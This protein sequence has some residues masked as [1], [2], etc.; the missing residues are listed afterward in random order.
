MHHLNKTLQLTTSRQLTLP[1]GAVVLRIVVTPPARTTAEPKRMPLNIGIALD[2]SG[3]MDGAKLSYAKAA[4]QRLV[5]RMTDVDSCALVTFENKSEIVFASMPMHAQNRSFATD[6][7]AKLAT[8][9][10]TALH[11]GWHDAVQAVKAAAE[12]QDALQRV[13]LLTDG[14]ANVGITDEHVLAQLAARAQSAGVATTTFG[15][16]DGYNEALLSAM[17]SAGEGNTYYIQEPAE[18][19]TFFEQELNQLFSTSM[20]DATLSVSYTSDLDVQVIGDRNHTRDERGLHFPMGS[21]VQDESRDVYLYL[22]ARGDTSRT[23]FHLMAELFGST[24]EGESVSS[25]ELLM[26]TVA[27]DTG[28]IDS[29]LEQ[30]AAGIDAAAAAAIALDQLS[31]VDRETALAVFAER[32][33]RFPILAGYPAYADAKRRLPR[34][35]D[36]AEMKRSRMEMNDRVNSSPSVLIKYLFMLKE[37]QNRGAPAEEIARMEE[38]IAEMRKRYGIE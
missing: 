34:V 23:V 8:R 9:G 19:D 13:F 18:I 11:A 14:Q 26:L 24:P 7:I 16:G 28:E 33:A 12:Q 5:S 38:R 3:S 36:F 1:N 22:A 15:L 30:T 6:S 4:A 29:A 35:T 2:I 27:P 25:S 10:S 31:R 21:F 37:M 32:A 20:R 17:A